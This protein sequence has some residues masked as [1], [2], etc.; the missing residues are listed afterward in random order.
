MERSNELISVTGISSDGTPYESLMQHSTFGVLVSKSVWIFVR[1]D[2]VSRLQ[3]IA[4]TVD[5]QVLDITTCIVR[6]HWTEH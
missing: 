4:V 5:V 3:F 6:V 1:V 2:F